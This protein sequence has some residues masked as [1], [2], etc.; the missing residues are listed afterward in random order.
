MRQ[1]PRDDDWSQHNILILILLVRA[2]LL[3]TVS[4]FYLCLLI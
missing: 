1:P 3:T 4:D 2:V